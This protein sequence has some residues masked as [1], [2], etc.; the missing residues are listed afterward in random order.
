MRK[1]RY[2]SQELSIS[3]REECSYYNGEESGVQDL[4]TTTEICS[5]SG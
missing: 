5:H 2:G 4:V 1:R 3:E